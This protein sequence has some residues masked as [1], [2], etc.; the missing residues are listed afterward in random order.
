M[1]YYHVEIV[2]EEERVKYEKHQPIYS[3]EIE[4]HK[5]EKI[6]KKEKKWMNWEG[7]MKEGREKIREKFGGEREIKERINEKL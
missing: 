1:V 4:N 3:S 2:S 6:R 7:E 5:Y